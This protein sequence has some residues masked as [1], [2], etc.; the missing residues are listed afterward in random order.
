M[1]HAVRI[2][3]KLQLVL[4]KNLNRK[5]GQWAR[6][7]EPFF[8][9]GYSLQSGR[10][11]PLPYKLYLPSVSFIPVNLSFAILAHS[12][13]YI[14]ICFHNHLVRNDMVVVGTLPYRITNFFSNHNF[15]RS[16][17]IYSV[18]CRGRYLHRPLRS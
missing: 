4:N 5:T 15:K 14:P 8:V 6:A 7:L 13:L 12:C 11:K 18:G 17:Y 3:T 1:W 2:L 9:L 16:N 10:S